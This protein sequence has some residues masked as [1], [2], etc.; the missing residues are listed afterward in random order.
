MKEIQR[1]RTD[2][3]DESCS[4]LNRNQEGV[5]LNEFVNVSTS[6]DSST[7]ELVQQNCT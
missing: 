2:R 7:V 6:T 1:K 5:S 4:D 3:S